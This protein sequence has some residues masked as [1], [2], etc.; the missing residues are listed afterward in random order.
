M[1]SLSLSGFFLEQHTLNLSGLECFSP[2]VSSSTLSFFLRFL[3]YSCLII[4]YHSLPSCS[5]FV[6]AGKRLHGFVCFVDCVCFPLVFWGLLFGVSAWYAR[7]YMTEDFT[8]WDFNFSD[9]EHRLVTSG[10]DHYAASSSI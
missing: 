9:E 2:S 10:A 6:F 7:V 4:L 5:S 8:N 3:F 1:C